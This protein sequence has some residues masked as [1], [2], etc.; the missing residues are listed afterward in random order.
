[1][2]V[3]REDDVVEERN[4]HRVGGDGH[5]ARELEILGARRRIPARVVVHEDERARRLAQDD[6]QNVARSDRQAVQTAERDPPRGA[7]SVPAVEREG[8]QLLVGQRAEL[9]APPR[10]HRQA[11]G[12]RGRVFGVASGDP[13][14][15]LERRDD[16]RG[17]RGTDA[18]LLGQ[19]AVALPPEGAE[20]ARLFEHRR[21]ARRRARIPA[22]VEEERHQVTV[23]ESFDAVTLEP[24]NRRARF[25]H[26]AWES[27]PRAT[28]ASR[29]FSR[30]VRRRAVRDTPVRVL[31]TG[32]VLSRGGARQGFW[33]TPTVESLKSGALPLHCS[34]VGQPYAVLLLLQSL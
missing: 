3:A 32:W 26:A 21:G 18:A 29:F 24:K 23:A 27:T 8:P 20:A 12:E 16:P 33:Q 9:R 2:P 14:A 17:A 4:P 7:E 22:A 5:A 6:A 15:Q 10:R 25:L 1:M 31:D 13:P 30:D 19:G 28:D 34:S 11:A